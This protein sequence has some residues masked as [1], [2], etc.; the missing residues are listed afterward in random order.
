ML[1][2]TGPRLEG[3]QRIA[4]VRAGGVG[5][6][7]FALPALKALKAGY[8][9]A[10]LTLLAVDWQGELLEGRGIV[11]RVIDMPAYEGVRGGTPSAWQ[12]A[13]RWVSGHRMRS[14]WTSICPSHTCS[15]RRRGSSSW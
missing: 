4:V 9:E 2:A 13:P 8:P 12:R 10:V 6:L 3:L 1:R 5:D 11:D 14:A 7:M 15:P